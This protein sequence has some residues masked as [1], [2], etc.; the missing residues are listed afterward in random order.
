MDFRWEFMLLCRLEIQVNLDGMHLYQI[1]RLVTRLQINPCR[2]I[3]DEVS[4]TQLLQHRL[5]HRQSGACHLT[6]VL[7]SLLRPKPSNQECQVHKSVIHARLVSMLSPI[8]RVLLAL[9]VYLA[10]MGLARYQILL[11][12]RG[13]FNVLH[14][15]SDHKVQ[16]QQVVEADFYRMRRWVLGH[17]RCWMMVLKILSRM[18]LSNHLLE[19]Q[20]LD[21]DKA[22]GQMRS[23]WETSCGR[24]HRHHQIRCGVNQ[25][26]A[27]F[28][29]ET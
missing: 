4:R 8:Y 25:I 18:R 11:V 1:H 3:W 27:R 13:T 10:S 16:H 24:L 20:H 12:F 7:S 17:E 9:D 22:G 23:P 26:K 28:S 15:Y 2:S 29:G 19:V 6:A 21:S 14:R 5:T